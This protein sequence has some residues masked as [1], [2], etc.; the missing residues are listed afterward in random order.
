MTTENK[1]SQTTAP[2]ISGE[3]VLACRYCIIGFE[4]NEP[5]K[6]AEFFK[7]VNFNGILETT[8]DWDKVAYFETLITADDVRNHLKED[9]PDYVWYVLICNAR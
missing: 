9:F 4:Y 2:A 5:M 7:E 6:H 1:T 3:P 8:D